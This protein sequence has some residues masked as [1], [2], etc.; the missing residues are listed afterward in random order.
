MNKDQEFQRRLDKMNA[1]KEAAKPLIQFMNENCCPHDI[2][3]IQIGNAQL[4]NGE[5][6]VPYPVPD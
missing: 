2:A 3:V 6:S 5:I 1:F 4:F